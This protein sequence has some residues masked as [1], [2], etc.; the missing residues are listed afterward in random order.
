VEPGGQ[1]YPKSS[2]FPDGYPA[3]EWNL[4]A[5]TIA[6]YVDQVL[7]LLKQGASGILFL[8]PIK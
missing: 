1:T 8:N 6:K 7:G 2:M 5:R 3:P 4:K